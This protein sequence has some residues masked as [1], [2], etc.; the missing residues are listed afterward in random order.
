MWCGVITLF[1]QSLSAIQDYGITSRAIKNGIL[2]VK[3]WDPRDFTKDNYATVD[4]RPYGGGPGM[5]MMAQPLLDALAAARAAS[6]EKPK[7]I[8]VSPAGKRFDHQ[9][10]RKLA[11]EARPLLF[12][13]GRYEGIDYRVIEHEVDEQISIGD[14]VISGGELAV[15]VIIDALTRWLPDALG[16][17][18]SAINDAFSE[19]NFG[20]L[21]CPH[22]TRPSSLAGNEVPAVLLGGDHQRIALWRRKQSLGQTWLYRPDILRNMKLDKNCLKLLQEFQEEYQQKELINEEPQ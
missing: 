6:P 11:L 15:M 20:L 12:I 2:T 17:D 16:H 3:A 7:V 18:E 9:L 8:Y 19:E 14:Y 13:A 22:Y 5:V 10:A 1:P 21:D 4:D